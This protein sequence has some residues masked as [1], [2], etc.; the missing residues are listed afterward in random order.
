MQA[1]AA[2]HL[3]LVQELLLLV[4]MEEEQTVFL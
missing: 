3:G 1:A 4:D 2:D